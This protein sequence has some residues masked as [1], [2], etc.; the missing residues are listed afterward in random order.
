MIV[1][2]TKNA[3]LIFEENGEPRQRREAGDL[4]ANLDVVFGLKPSAS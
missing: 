1:E 4:L 2:K 3:I